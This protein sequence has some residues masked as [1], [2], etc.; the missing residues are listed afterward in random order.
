MDLIRELGNILGI[1][2]Y[3]VL[4]YVNP[5]VGAALKTA[6]HICLLIYFS[7]HPT[8]DMVGALLFFTALDVGYLLK[9]LRYQLQKISKESESV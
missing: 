1:I 5:L 4:L 2:G 9:N 6:G 8:W 7:H 3:P